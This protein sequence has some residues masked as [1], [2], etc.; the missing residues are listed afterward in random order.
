MNAQILDYLDPSA[1]AW[2]R[3][4]AAGATIQTALDFMLT[5]NP[6]ATGEEHEL[7][8]F[9]PNVAAIGAA[10]GDPSG[11]YVSYLS[12]ADPHYAAQPYFFWSQPLKAGQSIFSF[13]VLS[14]SLTKNRIIAV[15][16][17]WSGE[18]H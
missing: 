5:I 13:K 9:N 3:T 4:T 7:R 8:E 2:N 17:S 16:F 11:K 15:E 12:S 10:Y 6:N 14:S 18:W 1:N